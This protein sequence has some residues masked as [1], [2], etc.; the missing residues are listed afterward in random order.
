MKKEDRTLQ[1]HL[2][3]I[4]N[5]IFIGYLIIMFSVLF[6]NT[7]L[8]WVVAA[9][10]FLIMSAGVVYASKYYKCPHCGNRLYPRIKV[11]NY[12]PNCGKD[13]HE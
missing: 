12:C 10:G 4:H 3:I 13:L 1:S 2:V 9:L 11:P 5:L 8:F 7:S 6:Q